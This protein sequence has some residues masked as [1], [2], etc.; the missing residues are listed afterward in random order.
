MRAVPLELKDANAFVAAHH[1]HNAPVKRDKWRFG[2]IDDNGKLIGVL[3]AAKPV[4]RMLDDGR[5]IEIVRCCT[6][7]TKNLCS[8]MLG[9]ARRI[10]KAMGYNKIISYILDTESGT[11]YKAAGW[12]KEADTKGGRSWNTPCRPRTTIAPVCNK[13]RWALNL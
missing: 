6:D 2:V 1:R 4:A 11:S 12:H 3:Q 13:Q 7:G 9:R 8:F 10:A 5:T